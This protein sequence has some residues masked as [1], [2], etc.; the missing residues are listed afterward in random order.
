MKKF[1]FNFLGNL[2][3]GEWMLI[4]FPLALAVLIIFLALRFF[5]KK[6]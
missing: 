3:F 5:G 4:I 1:L 2:G 6:N